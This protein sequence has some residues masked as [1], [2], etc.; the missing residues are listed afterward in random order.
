[1]AEDEPPAVGPG[2]AL[3]LIG[4]RNF[5]PYFIGNAS[6]ASGTWFQN[7]AASLFVYRHTHSPFLLG[8]LQFATFLPILVLAPWAGSAADR[9][10]RR[11]LVLVAQLVATALGA[12][13]AGLAW[14]GLAPVW[15]VMLIS[16]GLGVV[17]AFSA[18]ASLA[19]LADL[20][21]RSHLQ[22]AVALNS[23]TYNLARAVGPALAALS[24]RKLGI[25]ASFAIN[26]GSYLVLVL[27]VLLVQPAARQLASRGEAKLRESLRLVRAE[28][29]LLAF[30]LIV[31]AVGFASD[32]VNTEAPAFAHAF[33]RPDTDAGYLIGAFGAGAVSAAFL[34]AG[35]VAGSRRRMFATLVL[36]GAGVIGFSLSPWLPVAYVFLAVAGF[37]YLASNTS[38][39]SRLQLDVAE[40]QRGRIMALWSVAFLG[41][42]PIASLTDGAI[43]GAFGVRPA[44]VVLALP[45][46]AGAGAI[47]FLQRHHRSITNRA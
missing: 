29:R 30:L 1:M 44:G 32:P 16:L 9:F 7:L 47:Y 4:H 46:L 41:L 37:G 19:L 24:V 31:T 18:P 27:G 15:V 6:S 23:M 45:A 17:S 33:G 38:A 28:P 39:T 34:L 12:A 5:L 8:V 25:P 13:L 36:L 11:K 35:R 40:H 20:V 14:A 43:A 21:P 42:R 3:R 2:A 22:S 10:D 26:S